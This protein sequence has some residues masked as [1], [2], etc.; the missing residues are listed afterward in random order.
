MSWSGGH[1]GFLIEIKKNN[2]CRWEITNNVDDFS[3][4]IDDRFGSISSRYVWEK[5]WSV[6]VSEWL[7]FNAKWA[8]SQ[9]YHG[10]NK[11]HS[12][13]WCRLCTRPP[14]LLGIFKLLAL[15]DNSPQT[16]S[17]LI[18]SWCRAMQFLLLLHK[19]VCLAEKQQM[20]IS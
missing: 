16:D 8:F 17:S 2:L 11:L 12:M 20:P 9:L 18:S 7:L 13:K 1:L 19:V 3:T 14:H 4:N 10:Q 15:C 6:K 5:C